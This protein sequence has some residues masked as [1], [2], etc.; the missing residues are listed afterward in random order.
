MAKIQG[1]EKKVSADRNLFVGIA[2]LVPIAF[3]PT[4]EKLALVTHGAKSFENDIKY[5]FSDANG[6]SSYKFDVWCR[7][8]YTI[9]EAGNYMQSTDVLPDD[10]ITEY[11]C[12]SWWGRPKEDIISNEDGSIKG[13]WYVNTL[14]CEMEWI[15][16][17][18]FDKARASRRNGKLRLDYD[19]SRTHLGIQGEKELLTWLSTWLNLEEVD[20]ATPFSKVV[21]GDYKEINEVIKENLER[22]DRIPR[23][24]KVLLGIKETDDAT[25]QS[26]YPYS[27]F[28]ETST[29]FN[30]LRDQLEKREWKDDRSN[31]DYTLRKY[32]QGAAPATNPV[33]SGARPSGW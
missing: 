5:K 1:K 20:F 29:N 11:V 12:Y 23:G 10:T 16:E 33:V 25:Y 18:N 17:N 31:G 22:T 7:L 30:R 15:P 28:S 24:F 9:D 8:D 27:M 2:K 19:H 4:K 21:Q 14:T 6:E 13:A 32:T 26:V 3:N